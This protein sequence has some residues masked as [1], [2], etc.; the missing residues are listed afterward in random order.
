M[1]IDELVLAAHNFEISPSLQEI[2][3]KKIHRLLKHYGHFITDIEILLK[4]DNSHSN[5]AEININ[6]Q[7]KQLNASASTN[8][9]YKSID[10]MLIKIKPQLEKYKELHFG[11]H[12]EQCLQ[13][14]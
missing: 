10:D 12:R 9:M 6:V 2:V 8:D 14:N 7:K 3:Y 4:I 11:H 1:H 13:P 5:I